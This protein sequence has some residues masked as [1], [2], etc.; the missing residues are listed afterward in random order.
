MTCDYPAPCCCCCECCDEIPPYLKITFQGIAS[1]E[2]EF[3]GCR[4]CE[5]LNGREFIVPLTS[6]PG[7]CPHHDDEFDFTCELYSQSQTGKVSVWA[8][9]NKSYWIPPALECGVEV[10]IDVWADLSS[11][12]KTLNEPDNCMLI[13]DIPVRSAGHLSCDM[14]QA[15][16]SIEGLYELP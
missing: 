15:T 16:V 6:E 1:P 14:S 11:F 13:E 2:D 12:V 3:Q 4:N 10:Q 7:M 5:E 8:W 9:I